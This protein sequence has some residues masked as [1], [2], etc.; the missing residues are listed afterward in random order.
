VVR[1]GTCDL[2]VRLP[3]VAAVYQRQ[4]SVPSRGRLMST[5]GYGVEGLV[6]LTGAVVCLSCCVSRHRYH[7]LMPI[8]CHFQDCKRCCSTSL[9]MYKQRYIN[10]HR[11]LRSCLSENR[12][13]NFNPCAKFQT[14]RY[15]TLQ[16]F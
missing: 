1:F 9:L 10:T 15:L 13:L 6:W 8:S 3:P 16:F 14:F 5:T 11:P 12:F 7:Y 4:L 2:W